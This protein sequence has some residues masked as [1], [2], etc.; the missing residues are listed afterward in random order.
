MIAVF[1]R[2]SLSLWL[3]GGL[4][5]GCATGRPSCRASGISGLRVFDFSHSLSS[6]S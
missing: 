6:F 4:L 1:G 5:M 2:K 3:I